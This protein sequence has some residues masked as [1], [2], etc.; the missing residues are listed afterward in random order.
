MNF[1]LEWLP[2]TAFAFVLIFGRVG[3]MLMLMPAFGENSIPARLRLSFAL[4]FSLVVY[5][6]VV[7]GIPVMPQSFAGMGA[8]LGHEM[9][10]GFILGGI[11]RMI[12]MATQTAGSIIAF[13]MGLSMAMAS[14]PSQPG[15]QGAIIGNFLTLLGITLIFVTDLHHMVLAAVYDS[16]TY[17]PVSAPLMI[18]DAASAAVDAFSGAFKVG[19]QMSAPFIIF[20]LVF[21]LGLGLLARLMPQLQVFFIAMPANVGIGLI[22]LAV[23]LISMMGWYLS[24]FENT[25]SMLLG[26]GV[27]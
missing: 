5:P 9:A 20:G 18:G 4:V 13:Q 8:L 26:S 1:A 14:D 6:L 12:V 17:F 3:T 25:L 27:T 10:V 24:Q 16:Y 23:L 21:Y 15:V 22:L 11:A 19:V 7:S 2:Q